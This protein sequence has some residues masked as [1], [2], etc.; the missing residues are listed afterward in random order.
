MAV[1]FNPLFMRVGMISWLITVKKY[2]SAHDYSKIL[3]KTDF[4]QEVIKKIF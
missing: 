1:T 4:F 3:I 2:L